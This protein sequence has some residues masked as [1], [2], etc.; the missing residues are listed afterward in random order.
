MQLSSARADHI[1]HMGL[2]TLIWGTVSNYRVYVYMCV[3]CV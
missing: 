3:L 1:A 2:P